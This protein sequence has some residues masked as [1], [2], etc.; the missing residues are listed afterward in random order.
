DYGTATTAE[1]VV[2][3][4]TVPNYPTTGE[5]PKVT[6]DDSSTLPNGNTEG[7][8]DVPVTVTYPDGTV[9][10]ITVPVTTGKQADNDKYTPETNGVNHPYGTATTADEITNTVTVPNYPTTGEQPKVTVDD[11]STLPNGNTE[12]TV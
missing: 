1:D 7:T 12:G 9:D 6:V 5:Q 3:T 11:P 4:V 8:V 2:G 10:H